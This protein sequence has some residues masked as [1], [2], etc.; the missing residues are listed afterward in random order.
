VAPSNDFPRARPSG[1]HRLIR[2]ACFL[3]IAVSAA[4]STFWSLGRVG[5]G[6][7][8]IVRAATVASID[9]WAGAP[10]GPKYGA[11]G[12]ERPRGYERWVAVGLSLGLGYSNGSDPRSHEQFH[13]VLLEPSAFDMFL[14]TGSFPEGTMLALEIAEAG[15]RVLPART[16]LFANERVALEL[17]VKDHRTTP[18]GWAYYS[19]GDGTQPSAQPLR[20]GACFSCHRAH[21]ATDNVFTQFYPR[22]QRRTSE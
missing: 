10:G 18:D 3:A 20:G 14:R 4:A 9:E 22:L 6:V 13:Q 12:L 8:P 16:G 2:P 19:F 15:S 1:W 7:W 5:V 11:N 21:A 17:A